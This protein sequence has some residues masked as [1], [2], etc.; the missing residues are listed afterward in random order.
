[1]KRISPFTF[2][3]AGTPPQAV[4]KGGTVQEANQSTFPGL[5][6]NG[7]AVYL[8]TLEPGAVRI[9]HWHPDSAELDYCLQGKVRFGLS[10]PDGEWQSFE[11]TAGQRAV[12]D[13]ISRDLDRTHPM[14]RLL[15]GEVGSGKT[16]VALLA[17]LQIVDT[18][19]QAVLLAPTEVLAAQHFRAVTAMLGDLAQ[20]GMLGGAEGATA[21]VTSPGGDGGKM[22]PRS[23][24]ATVISIVK[25]PSGSFSR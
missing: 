9:P 7:L 21:T 22:F 10:E 2:D 20:A 3:L 25:R 6:G 12:L 17:M 13:D 14:H 4:A 15:Q 5:A 19:G 16:V 8:I 24:R 18:G 23:F 11:L 1:M